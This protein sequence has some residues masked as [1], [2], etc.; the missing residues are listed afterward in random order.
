MRT[1]A[2]LLL[3]LAAACGTAS[4][5]LKGDDTASGD[6]A[7]TDTDADTDAD[8]DADADTDTDT[9]PGDAGDY[10]GT[11]DGTM[12]ISGGHG[13]PDTVITC[14]GDVT[15]A[16]AADGALSGDATCA[17]SEPNGPPPLE[18]AVEGHDASGA[19]A[20]TWTIVIGPDGSGEA[21]PGTGAVASGAGT[22]AGSQDFGGGAFEFRMA[23]AR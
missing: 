11:V 4:I 10:A 18:G 8:S 19:L 13:E 16:I 14:S 20:G 3:P 5:S 9:D 21:I 23:F 17:T 15:L 7:D 2:W 6:S 1:I 22:F 12:T